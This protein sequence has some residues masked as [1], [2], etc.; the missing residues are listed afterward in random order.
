MI[1][2]GALLDVDWRALI[3][4]HR[5]AGVA[6]AACVALHVACYQ[7]Y[8][9]ARGEWAAQ[10]LRY[11]HTNPAS[12]CDPSPPPPWGWVLIPTGGYS[13]SSCVVATGFRRTAPA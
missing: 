9:A 13:S 6:A 1:S 10:A 5:A 8:W 12:E 4:W 3:A 2:S 11:P 7:A